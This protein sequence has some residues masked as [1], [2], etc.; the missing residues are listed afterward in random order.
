MCAPEEDTRV[1][2]RETYATMGKICTADKFDS[3]VC[4]SCPVPA[5]PTQRPT[6]DRAFLASAL[7][8]SRLESWRTSQGH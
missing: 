6:N 4:A 1:G 7:H 3:V 5:P 2:E 8:P